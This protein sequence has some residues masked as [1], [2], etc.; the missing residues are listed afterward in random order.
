MSTRITIAFRLEL[1][2]EAD[3]GYLRPAGILGTPAVGR[4]IPI[5]DGAGRA[6]GAIDLGESG[7]LIGIELL[8]VGAMMKPYIAA[9]S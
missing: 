2:P 3:A 4:T 9:P 1:D 8:G 5:R 7:E 6:Y